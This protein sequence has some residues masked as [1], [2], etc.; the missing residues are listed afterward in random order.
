MEKSGPRE[1][2]ACDAEG[3][4]T[5]VDIAFWAVEGACKEESDCW[6]GDAPDEEAEG[7]RWVVL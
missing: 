5:S 7:V 6:V 4:N 1:V 3:W 2:G